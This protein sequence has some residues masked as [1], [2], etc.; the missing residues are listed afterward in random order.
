M[1]F[2]ISGIGVT[3]ETKRLSH[4]QARVLL[5]ALAAPPFPRRPDP[6]LAARF[7][8]KEEFH[9][10]LME[11]ISISKT[12]VY[13]NVVEKTCRWVLSLAKEF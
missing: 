4:W 12:N 3:L 1:I 10:P 6:L 9:R 13:K 7:V 11:I 2:L 5:P 8:F